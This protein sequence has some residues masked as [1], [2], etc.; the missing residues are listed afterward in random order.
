MSAQFEGCLTFK[1]PI[2]YEQVK[3][4]ETI[5]EQDCRDHPVWGANDLTYIDF[6]FNEDRSGLQWNN[7]EKSYAMAEKANLIIKLMNAW[8]HPITLEGE[9]LAQ[10]DDIG[11]VWRLVMENNVA[12]DVDV[13]INGIVTCPECE[14]QFIPGE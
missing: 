6:E 7:A 8:G 5:L 10:G 4:L 3:L 12:R 11:D 9:M 1:E 13:I 14:H 2:T